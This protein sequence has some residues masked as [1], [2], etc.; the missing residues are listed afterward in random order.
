MCFNR[1]YYGRHWRLE[2]WVEWLLCSIHQLCSA[3]HLPFAGWKIRKWEGWVIWLLLP[4]TAMWLSHT[5]YLIPSWMVSN[6]I[7]VVTSVVLK[8]I[9]WESRSPQQVGLSILQT[10]VAAWMRILLTF[11]ISYVS[12]EIANSMTKYSHYFWKHDRNSGCR[13]L[14]DCLG[15]MLSR[16]LY[17]SKVK[18]H[19]QEVMNSMRN[20]GLIVCEW[21]S[22]GYDHSFLLCL[23]WFGRKW[24]NSCMLL[25]SIV[26]DAWQLYYKVNYWRVMIVVFLYNTILDLVSTQL[27]AGFN[28]M[29]LLL[30]N[31]LLSLPV[32]IG[33]I[34]ATGEVWN[35]AERIILESKTS[36][37][38]LPLLAASLMMGSL[39]NYCLFLCTLCN[40][41][42]TTTIVGTLRS[43]LGTV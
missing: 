22:Q 17:M 41:A 26:R 36:L 32:L 29:E 43:V 40:S 8:R 9:C 11:S 23:F 10:L 12:W 2:L 39:L 30:Y 28:S 21:H 3:K 6:A 20:D 19:H 27:Y 15:S 1:L 31:G 33:I 4:A 13:F 42:L 24:Y 38:F 37:M 7:Q 25:W 5:S 14:F 35:S 34:F 18:T 16:L